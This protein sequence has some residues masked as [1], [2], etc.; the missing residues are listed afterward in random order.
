MRQFLAILKDSVREAIDSKVLWVLLGLS[1]LVCVITFSI[2]FEPDPPDKAFEKIASKF[3]VIFPERGKGK[4][5]VILGDEIHYTASD[6]KA[7]ADGYTLRLTVHQS[8]NPRMRPGQPVVERP[9]DGKNGETK[10]HQPDGFRFAV[11]NWQKPA[12]TKRTFEFGRG[13]GPVSGFMPQD[14]APEEA[15]A[16]TDQDLDTFIEQQFAIHAG[17]PDVTAKRVTTGV[18]EPTYEFD[19]AVHSTEAVRGWPNTT[20]LFFGAVTIPERLPL[21]VVIWFIEEKLINS[22]GA[23]L[24]LLIGVVITGFFVPN[25]L[26]K[27]A[28]DLLITKPVSRPALLVYKYIG[29]LSYMFILT[30]AT[31]GGVWLVLAIRSGFWNPNFLLLIPILTFTFAILYAFSTL[32]AVLTRSAIAAILLTCGFAFFLYLVGVVKIQVDLLRSDPANKDHVSQ[33]LADVVDGIHYALPRY[34]D[35]DRLTTKLITDATLTPLDRYALANSQ[36]DFPSWGETFGVSLA[37]ITVMLG[38]AS[39]RLSM[40]DN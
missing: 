14:V 19:V 26:R 3:G 39:W 11:V 9:I 32:V 22:V 8:S 12:G 25:M 4:F 40:R 27:G 20:R 17:M 31:V 18:Q 21:G 30:V 37:F 13:V 38:L 28:L 23:A 5:P 10:D 35:V 34:K 36:I 15:A 16:L 2:S 33:T 29:G 7:A 1:A 6:V 24:T